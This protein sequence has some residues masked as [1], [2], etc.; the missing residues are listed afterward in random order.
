MQRPCSRTGTEA[1][2]R[3]EVICQNYVIKSFHITIIIPPSVVPGRVIDFHMWL[4]EYRSGIASIIV[5]LKL[6]DCSHAPL[7]H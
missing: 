2:G 7:H 5:I 1:R 4:L 3:F 6:C